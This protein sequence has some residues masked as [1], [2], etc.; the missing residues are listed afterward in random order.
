MNV[1][2]QSGKSGKTTISIYVLLLLT[3][4]HIR[5]FHSSGMVSVEKATQ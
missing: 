5:V 3:I 2:R 4:L 1:G